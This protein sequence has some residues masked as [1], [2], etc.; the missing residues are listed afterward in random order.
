MKLGYGILIILALGICIAGCTQPVENLT[1]NQTGAPLG[2]GNETPTETATET[3]ATET[4]ATETMA[5]ETETMTPTETVMANETETVMAN[6]TETMNVTSPG[7]PPE[8]PSIAMN[9]TAYTVTVQD[10]SFNPQTLEVPAGGTVVWINEGNMTQTVTGTGLES[11][12]DSG[13]LAPGETFEWMFTAP[14]TYNYTSQTAAGMNGTIIVGTTEA[15]NQ[16]A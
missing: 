8:T 9:E 15:T 3:M 1:D 2:L 4:T 13:L 12:F 5:N 10:G 7:V 6:E 16:T 11:N 14:G